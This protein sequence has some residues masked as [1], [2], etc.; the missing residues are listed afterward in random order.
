MS[1]NKWFV[2]CGSCQVLVNTSCCKFYCTAQV[3]FLE[4]RITK[5]EATTVVE[6]CQIALPAKWRHVSSSYSVCVV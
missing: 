2:L 1:Q 3:P 5:G 4:F 6:K